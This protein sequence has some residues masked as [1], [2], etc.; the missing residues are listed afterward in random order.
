MLSCD[1]SILHTCSVDT[2]W[3]ELDKLHVLV[4]EPGPADHG[5]AVPGAGVGRGGGEVRLA[6]TTSGHDGVLGAESVDGAILKTES[7][8]SATLSILHQQ[9]QG[10]VLD[11]VVAVVSVIR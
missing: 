9:I 3:V 6:S 11:K 2:S 4:G 8:H 7:D 10:K 1:W 5:G